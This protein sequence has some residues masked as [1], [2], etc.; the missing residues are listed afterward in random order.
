MCLPVYDQEGEL[1][2]VVRLPCC[3]GTREQPVNISTG[4]ARWRVAA[5]GSTSF[6]WAPLL[7][8]LGP[9]WAEPP[10]ARLRVTPPPPPAVPWNEFA[11]ARW[12]GPP[13]DAQAGEYDYEVQFLVPRCVGRRRVAIVGRFA[14]ADSAVILGASG[15]ELAGTPGPRAAQVRE[16]PMTISFRNSQDVRPE[17]QTLRVRVRSAGAPTGLIVQASAISRCEEG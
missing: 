6:E 5:A 10:T 4:V 16:F 2:G 7:F 8:T 13:G 1:E 11:P 17:M 14:A 9:G 12:I 3:D 15:M